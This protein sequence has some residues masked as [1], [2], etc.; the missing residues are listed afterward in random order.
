MGEREERAAQT[1]EVRQ[2]A[3]D[4]IADSY[5]TNKFEYETLVKP[6]KVD[7]SPEL[8]LPKDTQTAYR[9]GLLGGLVS[10][11]EATMRALGQGDRLAQIHAEIETDMLVQETILSAGVAVPALIQ[12]GQVVRG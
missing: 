9:I 2:G 1:V 4:F 6:Y 5:R 7:N 10:A 12:H 8:R 3:I 11:G